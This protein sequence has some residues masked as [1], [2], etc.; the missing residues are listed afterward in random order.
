MNVAGSIWGG[1][2][3]QICVWGQRLGRS[4]VQLLREL[5]LEQKYDWTKEAKWDADGVQLM[6]KFIERVRRDMH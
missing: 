1:I 6:Q 2:T 4:D 5:R 3:S